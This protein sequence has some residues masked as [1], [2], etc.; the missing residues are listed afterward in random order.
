ERGGGKPLVIAVSRTFAFVVSIQSESRVPAARPRKCVT[1]VGLCGCH[2]DV[3]VG[4]EVITRCARLN[5]ITFVEFLT[6]GVDNAPADGHLAA[7]FTRGRRIGTTGTVRSR[8]GRV[9]TRV[10]QVNLDRTRGS[11]IERLGV[12]LVSAR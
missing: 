9:E 12:I 7:L 10:I 4:R 6:S 5:E 1:G 3:E 11:Q 8:G 2:R